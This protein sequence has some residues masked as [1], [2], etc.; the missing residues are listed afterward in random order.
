MCGIYVCLSRFEAHQMLVA[1]AYSG[2]NNVGVR[3]TCQ[4]ADIRSAFL[5]FF[6]EESM[7]S[8]PQAACAT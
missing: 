7:R 3:E 1:P 4:P 5:D 2:Y 8:S 6:G